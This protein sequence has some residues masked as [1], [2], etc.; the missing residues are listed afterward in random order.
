MVTA[1]PKRLTKG[2]AIPSLSPLSTLSSLRIRFGILVSPMM[3]APRAAS[4]GATMEPV[5]AATQSGDARMIPKAAAVPNPMARGSPTPRRRVGNQTSWRSSWTFTREASVNRTRARVTSARDSDRRG[6]GAEV[7]EAVG[8]WVV[9]TPR[10][11]KK[12]GAL[13]ESRSRRPDSRDHTTMQAAAMATAS[14]SRPPPAS[15]RRYECP[16]MV[17]TGGPPLHG[18][19]AAAS[20]STPDGGH[21]AG[22]CPRSG[23]PRVSTRQVI[24]GTDR[25]SNVGVR[26]PSRGSSSDAA[27]EDRSATAFGEEN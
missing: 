10:M 7:D 21:Q 15:A 6:V 5:A 26:V 25:S 4:V 20:A 16:V 14:A 2:V 1:R 17:R 19:V 18:P 9:T 3:A 8:P 22:P 12:I 27:A 11:T 23:Y 13:I 24:M